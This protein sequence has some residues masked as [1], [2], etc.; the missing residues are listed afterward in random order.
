MIVGAR[1]QRFPQFFCRPISEDRRKALSGCQFFFVFGLPK[2]VVEQLK[3]HRWARN[4][5]Q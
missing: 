3:A 4:F 5:Y 2:K 1:F